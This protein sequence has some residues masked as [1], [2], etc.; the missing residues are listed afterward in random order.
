MNDLFDNLLTQKTE[1]APDAFLLKGFALSYETQLLADLQ[2]VIQAAPFRH[3]V[4]PGGFTMKNK[5]KL[6]IKLSL[7]NEYL[8]NIRSLSGRSKCL[9]FFMEVRTNSV[10]RKS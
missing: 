7:R 5:L 10:Y 4:T 2:Q 3:M 8:F 6:K 9:L 1:I